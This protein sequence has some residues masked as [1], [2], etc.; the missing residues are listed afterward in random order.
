VANAW[1]AENLNTDSLLQYFTE[2]LGAKYFMALAHHH[3]NFDNW[4]ST[5]QEWNSVNVGPK[6]DIIGEFNESAKKYGV[7]LRCKHA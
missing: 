5:Y 1:K 2:E 7:P 6:R 3:D 4:N